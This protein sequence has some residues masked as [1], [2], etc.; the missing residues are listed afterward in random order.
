MPG[1]GISDAA[2][3]FELVGAQRG[4]VLASSVLLIGAMGS[5][6]DA[7]F[8]LFACE[9]T[10]VGLSVLALVSASQLQVA[11]ARPRRDS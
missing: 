8:Q 4:Q 2:R 11:L 3:I 6:A 5:A 1:V 7:I 10:A 9:M